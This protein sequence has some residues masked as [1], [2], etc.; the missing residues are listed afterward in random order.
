MLVL[1]SDAGGRHRFFWGEDDMEF[2]YVL[3]V[4]NLSD[5][6]GDREIVEILNTSRKNNAKRSVTGILICKDRIFLQYIEGPEAQVADLFEKIE[7][8]KRHRDVKVVHQGSIKDR[9]FFDWEMG[10]ANERNMQPLQWKWKL[11]KLSLFSLAEGADDCLS[12]VKE[13]MGTPGIAVNSPS[14]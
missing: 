3:Y 6:C 2:S 10:F 4:S 5:G 9:V 11:D 12:F 1:G 7:S 8:D 14:Y 13:F